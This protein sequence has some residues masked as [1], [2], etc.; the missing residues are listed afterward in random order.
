MS[1]RAAF[2]LPG[3]PFGCGGQIGR[4]SQELKAKWQESRTPSVGQKA[5]VSDADEAGRKHVEQEA[6]QEFLDGKGHEVL[7]VAVRGVS[8]AKGNLVALQGD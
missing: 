6:A 2:F 4:S 7:L 8:P 5:E 1:G 3:I